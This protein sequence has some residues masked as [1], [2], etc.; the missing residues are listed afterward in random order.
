MKKNSNDTTGDDFCLDIFILVQGVCSDLFQCQCFSKRTAD[1]KSRLLFFHN[2]QEGTD[3]TSPKSGY[4]Y[5][6]PIIAISANAFDEDRK[7]SCEAGMNAHLA[8]SIIVPELL[9][10]LGKI[11]FGKE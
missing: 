2:F 9:D 4:S 3:A 7:A 1:C 10:T 8:K 6:Y 5:E 11:L